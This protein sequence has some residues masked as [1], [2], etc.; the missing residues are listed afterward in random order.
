MGLLAV[1]CNVRCQTLT[2]WLAQISVPA[3]KVSEF[4]LARVDEMPPTGLR[5]KN[6]GIRCRTT[7]RMQRRFRPSLRETINQVTDECD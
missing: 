3:K 5:Q 2:L 1:H 7:D 4:K 6:Y